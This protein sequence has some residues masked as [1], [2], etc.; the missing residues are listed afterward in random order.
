M[1]RL[2]IRSR[3]LL[4]LFA[5]FVLFVAFWS[6][7]AAEPAKRPGEYAFVNV[8]VIPMRTEGV[9]ERQTV[10]VKGD[11]IIEMGPVDA[12]KVD[13]GVTVID[14][15]GRYLLPG[16]ADMH[17]HIWD[18]RELPLYIANG[19]TT[20][21]N[22]W[23]E[24]TTLAMRKRIMTGELIGPTI[25]TGG[26]I[27]DGE[28]RIWR[29]SDRAVAP[30][31]GEKLVMSQKAVGYDFI[32]VYSNLQ[33]DVFDAIAAAAKR[34]RIPFAGHVPEAV[35]LE[36]AL[37]SGMA[38]IEHLT[39]FA[40]ATLADGLSMG[41]NSRS[42]AMLAVGKRLAAGEISSDQVFDDK[43]LQAMA[44]L[45]HRSHVWNVPTLHLERNGTLAR[46][47]V[48]TAMARDELQYVSPAM[49][50]GWYPSRRSDADQM[51]MKALGETVGKRVAALHRAGAGILAGTDAPNPHV[52]HGFA[53]H[54]ELA[55]LEQAG[56]TR[57][58][59]LKTATVN[60]AVFFGTPGAFGSVTIGARADLLLIDANPLDDLKNLRRRTGV[61]LRGRWLPEAK[62]Q[63]MLKQVAVH[64]RTAPDWFA[65]VDRLPVASGANVRLRTQFVST[66]ADKPIAADRLA[67]VAAPKGGRSVIAQSMSVGRNAGA[68][69][70][71][72]DLDESGTLVRYAF[73]DRMQFG[74][75]GS[76]ARDGATYRLI[77]D[78]KESQTITPGVD[79]PVLT[80][81]IADGFIMADRLRVMP[82]GTTRKLV[83]WTI[84]APRG[85]LRLYRQ[86]WTIV[87]RP[88]AAKSG[89]AATRFDIEISDEGAPRATT[90]LLNL[91]DGA[92]LRMEHSDGLFQQK[93][94]E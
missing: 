40:R 70:Y 62:L 26:R 9:V 59:V 73:E 90:L 47:E 44:A 42:P 85:G 77:V 8:S 7:R 37:H 56:L 72:L 32:K 23:G 4:L 27:I 24:G 80:G 29:S 83:A 1:S 84:I 81:T 93:R 35:P 74:Q 51:A 43:K 61:M 92:P 39:G 60:P 10:I 36:H 48:K 88:D 13:P 28:P 31:E 38:S 55:L 21:R 33:P 17:V 94:A 78:G 52:V 2:A 15:K 76:I 53:L 75:R 69:S 16:L 63:A 34:E 67:V 89:G 3:H 46:S 65:K 79:E 20:V 58:E 49:Q 57:F 66:Y 68:R 6:V 82:A 91:R 11:R 14:G 12:V 5:G 50:M 25:V 45:A 71:Q 64:Y 18:A 22:M 30:A 19:I 87:R 54:Q 86:N 41:A